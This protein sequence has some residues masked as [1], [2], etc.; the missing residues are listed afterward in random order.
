VSVS[1]T[2][3]VDQISIRAL[4]QRTVASP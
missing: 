1:E 4:S 2:H 3:A